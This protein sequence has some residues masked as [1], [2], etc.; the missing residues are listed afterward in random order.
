MLVYVRI[1][2]TDNECLELYTNKLFQLT[3]EET[4]RLAY[5]YRD[6]L[7]IR[8]NK[9]ELAHQAMLSILQIKNIMN[10]VSGFSAEAVSKNGVG[11][12]PGFNVGHS[13]LLQEVDL[14]DSAMHMTQF[15]LQLTNCNYC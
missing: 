7:I 15:C 2:L 6:I 11:R 8:E 3:S 10:R 5:S 14:I 4:Q 12:T 13:W 1:R 9:H